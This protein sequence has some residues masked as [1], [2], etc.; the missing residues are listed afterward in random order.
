MGDEAAAYARAVTEAVERALAEDLGPEGD[1]TAALVPEGVRAQF[2]LRARRTGV[3]AGRDCATE[4]FLRLD[5]GIDLRWRADDGDEV[6]AGDTLLE[7]A[8][9]LR[10]ILTGE[11]TALNFLGGSPEWPL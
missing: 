5:P 8:G 7:L 3:L 4:T 9:L 1:L 11:R 2:A 10:P 6:A